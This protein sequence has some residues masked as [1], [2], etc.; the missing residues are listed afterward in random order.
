LLQPQKTKAAWRIL[1]RLNQQQEC[2]RHKRKIES[3]EFGKP[4]PAPILIDDC[5]NDS[6][7]Q[8]CCADGAK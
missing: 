3:D 2:N 5:Q 7:N 6:G 4:N 1:S 8:L